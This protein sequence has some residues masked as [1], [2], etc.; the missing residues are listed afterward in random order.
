MAVAD[1]Y[2]ALVSKRC[3]KPAFSHQDAREYL[4]KK[5]GEDF[6]PTVIAAFVAIEDK[7]IGIAERYKDDGAIEEGEE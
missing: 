5:S 2:D 7:I 4:L 3:Y 6:D 1:V